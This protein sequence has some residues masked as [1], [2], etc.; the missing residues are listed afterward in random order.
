MSQTYDTISRIAI[1]NTTPWKLEQDINGLERYATFAIVVRGVLKAFVASYLDD[2]R[3][4]RVLEPTSALS[5]SMLRFVHTFALKQRPDFTSHLGIEFCVDEQVTES[6]VVTTILPVKI[7]VHS[8]AAMQLFH[9][10]DGSIQLSRAY[11]SCF[12]PSEVNGEKRMTR[13]APAILQQQESLPDD[14]AIPDT[15]LRGIYYFPQDLVH[16]FFEPLYDFVTFRI[17]ML[18]CL[19]Q[20]MQFLTHLMVWQDGV[21]D[22]QDP[23]PFWLSYQVH[24]P[25]RLIKTAFFPNENSPEEGTTA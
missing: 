13:P 25:L 9:G 12:T 17:S 7:S 21:Y 5:R 11:L 10:M 8:Q 23:L 19:H 22:F 4:Y 2:P 18:Q 24:L 14:V 1:A 16:L 15:Q 20:I 3:C 6:G